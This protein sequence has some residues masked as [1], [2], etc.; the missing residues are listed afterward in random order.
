[1]SKEIETERYRAQ[2][3]AK[4]AKDALR[5]Y[6]DAAGAPTTGENGAEVDGI[7][8]D[9]VTAAT[10]QAVAR[11]LEEIRSGAPIAVSVQTTRAG[12]SR[13]DAATF[14]KKARA[15]DTAAGIE[16]V[17]NELCGR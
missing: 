12:I 10:A 16:D 17:I 8:D 7:V 6:L 1:M 11:I 5:H 14:V 2:C 3:A 15:A 4:R 13:E 9:I